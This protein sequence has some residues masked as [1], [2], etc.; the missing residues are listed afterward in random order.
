[1]K[2]MTREHLEERFEANG[3]TVSPLDAVNFCINQLM[4]DR[5]HSTKDEVAPR[6]TYEELI[7]ALLAARQEIESNL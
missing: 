2:N 7:G 6:L 5:T 4:K 3:L 1:M